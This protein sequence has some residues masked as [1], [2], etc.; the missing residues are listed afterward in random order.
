MAPAGRAGFCQRGDRIMPKVERAANKIAPPHTRPPQ[1]L[2]LPVA[3]VLVGPRQRRDLGDLAGLARSIHE[4]GLLQPLVGRQGPEGCLLLAGYRRLRAVQELGWERV[5][6]HLVH[7]LGDALAALKAEQ[8]E[9]TCRKDFTPSEAVAIAGALEALERPQA[10]KR[11]EEGRKAGGKTAGK[12]RPKDADSSGENCPQAKDAGDADRSGANCPQAK[13]AGRTR[14]KVASAVGM[15][16]RTLEKAKAV[17]EAAAADPS[18][19][20]L[21][22]EMDT[23]GKVDPAFRKLQETEPEPTPRKP[24]TRGPTREELREWK[25]LLLPM[26]KA[27]VNILRKKPEQIDLAHLRTLADRVEKVLEGS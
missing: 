4:L 9:N 18:L 2:S 25:R 5:P 8:H 10:K 27:V 26:I 19:Q 15:S 22:D 11:Q 7:G 1:V 24:R 14:D 13:D 6:V 21:A 23:T 12:G 17:V 3:E 16:G 20:P